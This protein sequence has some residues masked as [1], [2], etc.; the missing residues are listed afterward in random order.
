MIRVNGLRLELGFTQEDLRSAAARKL[1]LPESALTQVA[2]AKKSV[3]ARKKDRVHFVCAAEVQVD[4]D[5]ARLVS[6]ARSGDV[7]PAKPYRYQ[8]PQFPPLCQRPVVVGFGPAGM[9]AG[10][11][12]AQ[13]G[14]RPIILERGLPVEERAKKVREFWEHRR[15]DPECNV[16]FGEGGAGAFSDGKLTTGTADGRI[17]K[18]LEELVSA[19]APP[20]ILTDGKPHIGT[21]RLP[22]VVAKIREQIIA[23]G[24]EVRFSTRLT[25]L[26]AANG[27]VTGIQAET[28]S[29]REEIPCH[30]VILA[31][32]HSARDVFQYLLDLGLPMAP[33]AFSVG[34]RIE[35][36]AAVIDRAQYGAFAGHPALG[37]ADYKLSCRLENGRGV[38]T[39]CMCPGGTVTGAASEPG[40]V[41]T[42]GMSPWA[43]D[44]VNSNA[45][46]LV[47]VGPEDFGGE[48]PLAG[49][50]FQRRIEG[51]AFS[52]GG[53]GFLAPAQRVADFLAGRPSVG[54]GGVLP[55][56]QPGVAPGDVS[57]CL[58]GFVSE[59]LRRAL[60]VLGRQLQGFDGGDGVLTAPETRSSSPVRL[61]RDETMQSPGLRGLYPCG[62]GAGYAGGIVSAAVDGIRVAEM[63]AMVKN[64]QK[65]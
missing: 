20:E 25:G 29:G 55:T 64:S 3:D 63:L 15:L 27:Q 44:G 65:T 49:V 62:E 56:Y 4:G 51:A 22:S 53:G 41:V 42:N 46:L 39:F 57:Q 31:V 16:Q 48:G 5:E 43:R 19:G 18:V 11:I 21:D 60:P 54:F 2:L 12:L 32:G 35:Q 9:F 59:S 7:L 14:Q 1:K 26:R 38:Y 47:G 28:P 50:E 45:A 37:A 34:V 30:Q 17:R 58:P 23:L 8:P 33:K 40:G 6:R 52:Y 13:C 36:P 10:L 24:G 61:L